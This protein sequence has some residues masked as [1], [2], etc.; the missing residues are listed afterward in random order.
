MEEN[1]VETEEEKNILRLNVEIANFDQLTHEEVLEMISEIMRD[2]ENVDILSIRPRDELMVEVRFQFTNINYE[3]YAHNYYHTQYQHANEIAEMIHFPNSRSVTEIVG[4]SRRVTKKDVERE[5]G[6]CFTNYAE[7][8]LIRELPDCKHHYH[9][10]CLDK[11]LKKKGQCP[12][13]RKNLCEEKVKEAIRESAK[14]HGI[15]INDLI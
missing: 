12:M 9:Q 10:R 8:E 14:E 6:I 1:T 2:F 11:W 15:E 4:K 13:C 7:R 3:R 5:C